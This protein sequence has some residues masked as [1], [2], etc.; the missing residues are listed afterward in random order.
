MDPKLCPY[1][2]KREIPPSKKGGGR[3]RVTCLSEDCKKARKRYI[4]QRRPMKKG[5]KFLAA[6]QPMKKGLKF[7][8]A[9]QPKP[10]KPKIIHLPVGQGNINL[11]D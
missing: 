8:A 5:L 7:L 6:H 9:H 11:N 1:C 4:D 3:P 2:K 10:T